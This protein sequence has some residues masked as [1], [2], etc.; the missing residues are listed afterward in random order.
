MSLRI[1]Q[2]IWKL[3]SLPCLS[4]TKHMPTK[5]WDY[6]FRK[7]MKTTNTATIP[8][9]HGLFFLFLSFHL[10]NFHILNM[11]KWQ[12]SSKRDEEVVHRLENKMRERADTVPH[13]VMK[14]WHLTVTAVTFAYYSRVSYSINRCRAA[15]W[16]QTD[17]I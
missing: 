5:S 7:S 8:H 14:T 15:G 16:S 17:L 3:P 6:E 2:I 12:V 4:C 9:L 11:Y 10:Y 13:Q 1:L